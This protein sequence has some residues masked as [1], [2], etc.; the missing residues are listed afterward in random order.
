MLGRKL[1]LIIYFTLTS[2]ISVSAVG[3]VEGVIV[4]LLE[5]LERKDSSMHEVNLLKLP[6]IL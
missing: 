2:K 6:H 5:E 1:S 3:S 4:L